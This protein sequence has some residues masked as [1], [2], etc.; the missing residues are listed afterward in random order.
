M[1]RNVSLLVIVYLFLPYYLFAQ[2][3]NAYANVTNLTGSTVS[4]N[5]VNESAD[6]YED[7]E[8]VMI[9]QVQ[10]NVIGNTSNTVNFGNLGG[11]QSAG[12]YEFVT[13][14][15]HTEAG[16]VPTSLTFTTSFVNTY[17][18]GPNSRVQIVSYPT[19]G[20]PDYATTNDITALPWDGNIGGIIAF[21][22]NGILTLN[23]NVIADRIGFRGG[24]RSSN[25]N[26]PACTNT[27]L[28]SSS[29]EYGEKGEGIYRS[30]NNGFRRGRGKIL[31]GGGGSNHHNGGGGGGSNFSSGGAGGTGWNHGSTCSAA[32]S[33]GG[34]GG[35]DLSAFISANRLFLGGGGGGG[36]QNNSVGTRGANGGGLIFLQANELR[37]VGTCSNRRISANGGHSSDA[38]NDGA[39]GAG[40]GGAIV[41]NISNYNI[42]GACN[43]EVSANGGD[44]G[45][46]NSGGIHGGGG[47]GGQGVVLYTTA[48]PASGITTTTLVGVGGCNN[49][50]NPCDN[51]AS[52]GQGTS[53]SGIITDI[54]L[55]V[56]F[57]SF[58]ATWEEAR[59]AVLLNWA[60]LSEENSAYF[61]VERSH[62]AIHFETIHHQEATGNSTALVSYQYQDKK[63]LGGM[64]YYRIRQVDQNGSIAYSRLR[65]VETPS[66]L[67]NIVV[68]PNPAKDKL[69]IESTANATPINY[70][71]Y[72]IEGRLLEINAQEKESSK[73]LL[74]GELPRGVYILRIAVG[75]STRNIKVVLQ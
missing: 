10:D 50:S 48:V 9:I 17:N 1:L 26:G 13:I 62:D 44:G 37:T 20:N 65:A 23:H 53:N 24:A 60:T 57:E 16:N 70:A 27:P 58:T 52:P 2:R 41:M 35:I 30:T 75:N 46:V 14:A 5:H 51:Q 11:I 49:N 68:Y 56:E 67:Q 59:K 47:G 36:Q 19:L 43:L 7:G 31:N 74:T 22:V 3:V 39:G 8:R 61:V 18:I 12:L 15:S 4:I 73:H 55:P 6:T 72:T 54:L 38:G 63:P 64:S 28:T 69:T 45:R 71:L 29:G 33:A 42:S 66:E 34:I 25:Q 21:R 40:G 32:N